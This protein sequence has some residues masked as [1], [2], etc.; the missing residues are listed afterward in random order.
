MEK[1]G[2]DWI[3][4]LTLTLCAVLLFVNFQQGRRLEELERQ[5]SDAQ[6]AIMDDIRNMESSVY[7]QME[8]ANTLVRDWEYS[9]S[10]NENRW[11]LVDL[12][13]TLKEWQA[14]TVAELLWSSGNASMREG[15]VPLLG[16]AAGRFRGTLELPLS[17]FSGD[18]QF[19]VKIVNGEVQRRERLGGWQDVAMLLP[20]QIS[21]SGYGGPEYQN[22]IFSVDNY[23][24]YLINRVGEPA[25]AEEPVYFLQRNGVTVWEAEAAALEE[26]GYFTDGT[27]EAEGQA[28]D[29]MALFFTCRDAEGLRY[30]FPL[31]SWEIIEG[32]EDRDIR[33]TAPAA[34]PMLSWD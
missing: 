26:G 19:D 13:V 17:E 12:S 29:T 33:H 34:S 10:V 20:L 21:S 6:I 9:T 22:G 1:N 14:D 4:L 3:K 31:E 30:T 2:R 24:L 28:G 8:E 32:G 25:A 18:L 16:D 27:A 5:V 11:L 15:Y 7:R 23:C